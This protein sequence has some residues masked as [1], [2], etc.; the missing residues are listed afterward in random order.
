MLRIGLI[1]VLLVCLPLA[2][3]SCKKVTGGGQM[4]CIGP[5]DQV[6]LYTDLDGD[7]GF[8]FGQGIWADTTEFD[9]CSFGF[10]AR[11]A[12]DPETPYD[13]EA[14]GQVQI[15]DHTQ[16][17]V[18][19]FTA[20]D[21]GYWYMSSYPDDTTSQF[22]GWLPEGVGRVEVGEETFSINQGDFRASTGRWALCDRSVS[23]DPATYPQ[24]P[25]LPIIEEGVGDTLYVKIYYDDW[26]AEAIWVGVVEKGNLT[27]HKDRK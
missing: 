20:N 17:I 9:R 1:V 25:Y 5:W 3:A 8:D 13:H 6:G 23:P 19:H 18:A 24:W 7:G 16:G 12:D 22:S 14:K 21:D 11:P 10:N 26:N 15:V 2:L 27:I 4:D